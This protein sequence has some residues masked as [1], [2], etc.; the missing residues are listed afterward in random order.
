M[1]NNDSNSDADQLA[2]LMDKYL[3]LP[4]VKKYTLTLFNNFESSYYSLKDLNL[5]LAENFRSSHRSMSKFEVD[6][7]GKFIKSNPMF[8][9]M[10]NESDN[11][12]EKPK[13]FSS[14]Q[15]SYVAEGLTQ[16]EVV[17]AV[18]DLFIRIFLLGH[19]HLVDFEADRYVIRIE[20]VTSTHVFVKHYENFKI[21]NEVNW[22]RWE[23][24]HYILDENNTLENKL[25]SPN[26]L[27][28]R[29]IVLHT[30]FKYVAS[31]SEDDGVST[32]SP[33]PK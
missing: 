14:Y 6:S 23:R 8:A 7:F 11:S 10:R 19:A 13:P 9:K 24:E 22:E 28:V 29:P 33:P 12:R 3:S 27:S 4:V 18:L 1:S 2:R 26:S 17:R 21:T 5:V 16:D 15:Y 31:D 25:N 32:I 30:S 20:E